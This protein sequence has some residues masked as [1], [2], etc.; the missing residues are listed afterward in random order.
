MRRY[1]TTELAPT[2][3]GCYSQAV[4]SDNI[5]YHAGQLGLDPVTGQMSGP[6]FETQFTQILENIS[7]VAQAADSD[8]TQVIK[9]TVYLK[10]FDEDYPKVDGVMSQFFEIPYPARTTIGVAQ[11]PANALVEVDAITA[12]E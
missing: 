12:V 9:L 7:A 6:D 1:V 8:L 3:K 5:L 10:N 11:L 2:P 4:S